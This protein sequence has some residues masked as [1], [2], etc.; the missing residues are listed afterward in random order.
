MFSILKIVF[1]QDSLMNT[2]REFRRYIRLGTEIRKYTDKR[3]KAVI[4]PTGTKAA[5][6]ISNTAINYFDYRIRKTFDAFVESSVKMSTL[7]DE[8]LEDIRSSL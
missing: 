6:A 5:E 7:L 4:M 3:N 8:A 2:Q 1:R